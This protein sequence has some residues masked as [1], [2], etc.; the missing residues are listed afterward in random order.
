M[1]ERQIR[2]LPVADR[3]GRCIGM[4]AQADIALHEAP[5]KFSHLL[6]GIS[7]P[8]SAAGI[9]GSHATA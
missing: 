1:R 4:L 9:V 7:V 5:E 8:R 3:Q 6:A 2:R